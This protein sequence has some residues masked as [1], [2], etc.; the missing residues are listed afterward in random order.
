MNVR[1]VIF[2]ALI[3]AGIG[4]FLGIAAAEMSKSANLTHRH[5]SATYQDLYSNKYPLIGV[6]L[7][8]LI[9]AGQECV[10]EMKH[11]RDQ[12]R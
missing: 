10:R 8:L 5:T 4:W 12:E 9:G 2:S 1:L 11:Q 3:T 6:G 7:G